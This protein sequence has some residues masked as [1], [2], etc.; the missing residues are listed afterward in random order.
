MGATENKGRSVHL[1]YQH[2][3]A[4]D[5]GVGGEEFGHASPRAADDPVVRIPA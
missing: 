3:P 1:M 5:H 2:P 4:V